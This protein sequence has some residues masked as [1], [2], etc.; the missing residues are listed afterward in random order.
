M[1]AFGSRVDAIPGRVNRTWFIATEP[2][3]Y[4]GECSNY[5]AKG[6]LTCPSLLKP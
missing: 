2:G 5:A 4:Y 6:T 3:T 1:P